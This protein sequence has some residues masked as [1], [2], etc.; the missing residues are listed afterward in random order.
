MPFSFYLQNTL[1]RRIVSILTSKINN[2]Y[3]DYTAQ[4]ITPDDVNLDASS[5]ELISKFNPLTTLN[6]YSRPIQLYTPFIKRFLGDTEEITEISNSSGK[7]GSIAGTMQYESSN[8]ASFFIFKL[9]F[10]N[11]FK[12]FLYESENNSLNQK[13]LI[14]D[15]ENSSRIL[16]T[17][18]EIE[19]SRMIDDNWHIILLT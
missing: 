4:G 8:S 6:G 2:N 14:I 3:I 18:E 11:K 12:I 7:S 13:R 5:T 15:I 9:I 17:S 1:T 16:I 10:E 19:S